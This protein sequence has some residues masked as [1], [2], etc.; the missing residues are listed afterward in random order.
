MLRLYLTVKTGGIKMSEIAELKRN[1]QG[2]W[3]AIEVTEE[4]EYGP[5]KGN[6]IF[7]SHDHDQVW[8]EIANDP[9]RIYV[10]YAGSPIEKG[11][12]VAF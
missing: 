2:E 4:D 10:T 9:R 11:Y 7:H 6:L 3:L 5:T 12:A 8:G 1:Y